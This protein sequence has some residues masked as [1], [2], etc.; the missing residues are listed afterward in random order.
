MS[1]KQ[2]VFLI[3]S[4]VVCGMGLASQE[5]FPVLS[6]EALLAEMKKGS[7]SLDKALAIVETNPKAVI[8]LDGKYYSWMSQ[9]LDLLENERESR[10]WQ[11]CLQFSSRVLRVEVSGE[12]ASMLVPVFK[13]QRQKWDST[14]KTLDKADQ[15]HL[16]DQVKT[17]L[18]MSVE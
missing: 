4:F 14:L 5:S 11:T 13:Q 15:Q 12:S 3:F 10:L 16:Q 7:D 18:A 6:E 9:C 1:M 17:G 2:V 8:Q